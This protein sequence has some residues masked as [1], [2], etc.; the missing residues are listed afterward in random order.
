MG[1]GIGVTAPIPRQGSRAIKWP[2]LA[3]QL[4][5]AIREELSDPIDTLFLEIESDDES[6][7]ATIHPGAEPLEFVPDGEHIGVMAKTST[8]G[9][10]YHAHVVDLINRIGHRCGLAWNWAEEGADETGFAQ[11]HDFP[12]LQ[13]EMANFLKFLA[14]IFGDPDPEGSVAINAGLGFSPV[15]LTGVITPS[16]PR[17]WKWLTETRAGKAPLKAAQDFFVWWNKD[18]DADYWRKT[19]EML[20]WSDVR[21][22]PPDDEADEA[23]MQAALACFD[24]AHELDPRAKIPEP[25]IAELRALLDWSEDQLPQPPAP[26]LMGYFRLPM[27]YPPFGGWSFILPGYFFQSFDED[28]GVLSLSFPGRSVWITVYTVEEPVPPG[29][30]VA[31]FLGEAPPDAEFI[32]HASGPLLSRAFI[33]KDEQDGEEFTVLRGSAAIPGSIAVITIALDDPA[34]RDWAAEVF[35]TL[36]HGGEQA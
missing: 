35:R 31:D 6:L 30:M 25:E 24:R 29:Q 23:P 33:A 4:E 15:G 26:G 19:G 2:T 3:D 13:T 27:T 14:G 18:R 34:D 11:K 20:L 32:E 10:G 36:R 5:S 21:W 22:R 28:E 7:H 8:L 12:A 9:P 16:G 1:L 17:P